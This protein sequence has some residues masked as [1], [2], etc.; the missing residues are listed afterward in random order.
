MNLSSWL[1]AMVGPLTARLLAALGLSLVSV[2]GLAA[3]LSTLRTTIMGGLDGLPLA[4]LQ[5]GGL[6]GIWEALGIA[7]GAVAFVVAWHGT[8][9]WRFIKT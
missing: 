6:L 1:I 5:L 2:A 4:A 7:L 9:A 8:S 3:A